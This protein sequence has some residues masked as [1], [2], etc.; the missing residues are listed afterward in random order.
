M[1]FEELE[2]IN[3]NTIF[4]TSIIRPDNHHTGTIYENLI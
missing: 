4:K 2:P 3:G 1:R